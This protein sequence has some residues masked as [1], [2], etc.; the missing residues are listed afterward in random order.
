MGSASVSPVGI[1]EQ[2]PANPLTISVVSYSN[3]LIAVR[4]LCLPWRLELMPEEH[5]VSKE[6]RDPVHHEGCNQHKPVQQFGEEGEKNYII[7]KKKQK[8]PHN[9]AERKERRMQYQRIRN[10][11]Q[12]S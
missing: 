2:R 9:A 8:K 1:N 5:G 10:A 12:Y 7:K 3:N 4:L 11:K 6:K